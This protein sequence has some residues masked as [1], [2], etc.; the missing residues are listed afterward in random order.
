MCIEREGTLLEGESHLAI[1]SDRRDHP[2]YGLYGGMPGTTSNNILYH[3]NGS[4]VLPTMISTTMK[5]GQTLYH[6]QASGGGW[7]DPLKREPEKVAIDVKNDK[8]S[9]EAA[10]ESFGEVLNPET[11]EVDEQATEEL[12][13]ELTP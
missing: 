1:R 11:V 2:P 10:K 8:V 5:A 12:R 13:K 4:E 6:R 7:G 3:E 9:I